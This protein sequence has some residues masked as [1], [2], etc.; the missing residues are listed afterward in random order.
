[1]RLTDY[2]DYA[3]RVLMHLGAHPD[4]IMTTRQIA[5]A[6]DISHNH[7]TKIVHQ[8]GQCGLLTTTR[9]RTGGIQLARAPE[10]IMLGAVVRLT[11]PDFT[12]VECF[13]AS[14]NTCMLAPRC[15]LRQVLADATCAY[16]EQ[17]DHVPLSAL[18][19]RPAGKAAPPAGGTPFALLQS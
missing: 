17:L 18:L 10:Q 9:G 1:M 15:L 4:Q 3:L 13:S 7:L 2:T 11:E 6:H 8:L 5:L 19:P 12:M 16:L 14:S